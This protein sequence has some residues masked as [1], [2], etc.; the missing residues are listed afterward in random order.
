MQCSGVLFYLWPYYYWTSNPR[1]KLDSFD[2]MREETLSHFLHFP[3]I[4]PIH[5]P[6]KPKDRMSFKFLA[7]HFANASLPKNSVT[8]ASLPKKLS[9]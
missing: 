4:Y 7:L 8:N 2:L 1:S 3:F 5:Y 6:K 9:H